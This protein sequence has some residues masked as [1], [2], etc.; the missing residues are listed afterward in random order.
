[1]DCRPV[2]KGNSLLKAVTSALLAIL[3]AAIINTTK[4]TQFG[5]RQKAGG[6]QLVFGVQLILESNPLF[7]AASLDIESAFNKVKQYII[8][9]KLWRDPRLRELWYYF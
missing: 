2:V 6:S 7:V 5:S 4:P 3:K 1:M 8:L 9:E